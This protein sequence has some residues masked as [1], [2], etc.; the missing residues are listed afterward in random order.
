MFRQ[1]D[2]L[3]RQSP[4]EHFGFQIG[5]VSGPCR[6]LAHAKPWLQT[7]Q[8]HLLVCDERAPRTKMH[9]GKALIRERR[10]FQAGRS[11]PMNEKA[12]SNPAGLS[13]DNEV[14]QQLR[15]LT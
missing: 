9:R 5:D 12:F 10:I 2:R 8:F 11:E 3:E 14:R 4:A 13:G 7:E 1:F 6:G 15:P